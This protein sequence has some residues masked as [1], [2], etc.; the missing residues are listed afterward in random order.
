MP[1]VICA[2]CGEELMGSVNRCWRCGRTFV[3]EHNPD[4]LPP[5]RRRPIPL[6][7]VNKSLEELAAAAATAERTTSDSAR[8][9][10]EGA[11]GVLVAELVEGAA[12]AAGGSVASVA[13][14]SPP[15]EATRPPAP[16]A[17]QP[18]VV[19]PAP[20]AGTPYYAPPPTPIYPS[21][22]G[23]TGGAI[24]SVVLGVMALAALKLITPGALV[25]SILGV[26]MGVWGLHSDRRAVAVLGLLLNCV[27]MAI[28]GFLSAVELYELV[29]G[30]S[31]FESDLP[32]MDASSVEV[33]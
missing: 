29:H 1:K 12:V 28:S 10:A 6:E 32:P 15:P 7:L 18:V 33:E 9:E 17:S 19:Q 31:P 26:G 11:T 21:S 3:A 4:N 14:E 16:V 23:A 2:H 24:A 27:A 25:I 20:A 5:I 30:Y 8:Q 13:V 22:A